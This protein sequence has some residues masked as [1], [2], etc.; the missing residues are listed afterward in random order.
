[1]R[2]AARTGWGAP[3]AHA[4]W[5]GAGEDGLGTGCRCLAKPL[6]WARSSR[7]FNLIHYQTDKGWCKEIQNATAFLSSDCDYRG[8]A[9]AVLFYAAGC[10]PKRSAKGSHG[11]CA[12]P[13]KRQTGLQRS[14]ADSAHGRRYQ[15]RG[16]L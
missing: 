2:P 16:V 7:K 4:L 11:T 12:A 8:D 1:M 6:T 14:L 13:G 15:E 3:H 5:L 10:R 9:G